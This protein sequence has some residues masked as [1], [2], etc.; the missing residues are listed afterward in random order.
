MTALGIGEFETIYTNDLDCGLG[1]D[2]LTADP[3]SNRL[4]ALVGI[5]E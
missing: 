5:I 3:T 4:E 1:S 2:T